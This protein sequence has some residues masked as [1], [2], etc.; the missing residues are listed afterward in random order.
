MHRFYSRDRSARPSYEE[1]DVILELL[2]LAQRQAR[3]A[4]RDV[5][6]ASRPSDAATAVLMLR[7]LEQTW[8][9]HRTFD[10][11][12]RH[13]K[14]LFGLKLLM[15]R[16]AYVVLIAIAIISLYVMFDHGSF[17]ATA[18]T[19]AGTALLVQVAA[20]MAWCWRLVIARE[21]PQPA[22]VTVAAL[23]RNAGFDAPTD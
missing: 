19:E 6:E 3:E 22:P 4:A 23:A 14:R 1:G 13:D 7:S 9:E 18:V 5:V 17:P 2:T 15:A 10:G 8:Q 20:L 11:R 16:S 12:H 21:T